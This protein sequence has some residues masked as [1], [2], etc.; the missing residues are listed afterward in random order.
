MPFAFVAATMT[1]SVL[2]TSSDAVEYVWL[3]ASVMSRQ[4][5]PVASQRCHWYV[6]EV[7]V[8]PFQVPL[9][10]V[11]VFPSSEEPVIDGRVV[12]TGAFVAAARITAVAADA[13]V[14]VPAEFVAVTV[15]RSRWPTSSVVRT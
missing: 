4:P 2:P 7:G 1:R 9:L 15:T 10:A 6:N 8:A 3:V 13:R 5:A 11:S 14:F 12:A